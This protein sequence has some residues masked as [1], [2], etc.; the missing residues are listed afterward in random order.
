MG[1]HN[2]SCGLTAYQCKECS[3]MWCSSSNCRKGNG[4]NDNGAIN[5]CPRCNGYGTTQK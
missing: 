2:C 1:N 3:T 4:K 5:K